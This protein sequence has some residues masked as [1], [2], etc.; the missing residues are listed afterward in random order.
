MNK[1]KFLLVLM[2]KVE[3]LSGHLCYLVKLLTFHT[4]FFV[5]IDDF[6]IHSF[7]L[8]ADQSFS[9]MHNFAQHIGVCMS[10]CHMELNRLRIKFSLVSQCLLYAVF[11]SF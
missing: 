5:C 6:C 3:H 8:T 11:I 4:L 2:D 7:I 9:P 1:W 10:Q